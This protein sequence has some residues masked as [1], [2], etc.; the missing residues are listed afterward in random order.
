M[1]LTKLHG[2]SRTLAF[3]LTVWYA[4]IFSLSFGLI[5]VFF[6]TTTFSENRKRIDL[7]LINEVKEFSFILKNRGMAALE[8]EVHTDAEVAGAD[9]VFFRVLDA[10][11]NVLISSNMAP[12]GDVVV[13]RQFLDKMTWGQAYVFDTLE[14]P[15]RGHGDRVIYGRIGPDIFA[16]MGFSIER[17]EQLAA[18]FLKTCGLA[19]FGVLILAGVVGWF[20]ARRA[21]LG[22]EE[23]TSAANAIAEG[24]LAI[25]VPVKARGDE[26]ERLARTFNRMAD[27]TQALL[28][29]MREMTDNIAHD[30]RSPVA[31]IRGVAEMVLM[32]GR[33]PERYEAMPASIIE[34]CDNLL[35]MINTM[36]YISEAEA[37][38]VELEKE[39]VDMTGLVVTACELFMP[40]AEEKEIQLN[41]EK[42]PPCLVRGDLSLLQRAVANLLNNALKYTPR[43]GTVT[44]TVENS[45]DS[46][47]IIVEDTGQGIELAHVPH[48]FERFYRC[49]KSRSKDGAGLGLALV[50]AIVKAHGGTVLLE[51]TPGQ[52]SRFT[53]ILPGHPTTK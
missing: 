10:R 8:N 31:R 32:T 27:R 41:R 44:V 36:L 24:A 52:G 12:W 28:L 43:K 15:G 42:G 29:Q 26:I 13:K 11:G 53:V 5:I 51:S 48:I 34:E 23:V 6:Y 25:R 50:N 18:I 22:V 1:A 30:L 9:S 4:G 40:L 33:P 20:M 14:I 7:E 38:V 49:D 2:L 37:G 16:Q 35:R 46:A 47:I 17:D 45:G 3:R 39:T 19:V 21:L